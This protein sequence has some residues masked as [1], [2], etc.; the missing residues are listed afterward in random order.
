M[1]DVDCAP[2]GRSKREDSFN[3]RIYRTNENFWL[4]FREI[5]IIFNFVISNLDI[6]SDLV[7]RNSNFI[8]DS[9][10]PD[11]LLLMHYYGK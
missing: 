3:P 6:V 2:K 7:F 9:E 4:N 1:V 8:C 11:W 10:H 5:A